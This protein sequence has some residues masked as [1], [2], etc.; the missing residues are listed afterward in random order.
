V[1]LEAGAELAEGFELLQRKIP[2]AGQGG[3]KDRADVAVRK[4]QAVALR[5]KGLLGI[6]FQDMEIQ[7]GENVRHAQGTRGVAGAGS[8]ELLDDVLTDLHGREG[9]VLQFCVGERFHCQ[10]YL[11]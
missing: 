8:H 1:A 2:G 9:Q 6:V 11:Q 4:H 5:P 7:G 10:D 3:V